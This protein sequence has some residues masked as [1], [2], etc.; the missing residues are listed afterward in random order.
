MSRSAANS[1]RKAWVEMQQLTTVSSTHPVN[2]CHAPGRKHD[3]LA[4]P[5]PSLA[6]TRQ[7]A[8]STWPDDGDLDEVMGVRGD[9]GAQHVDPAEHRPS[10]EQRVLMQSLRH[11]V[12][13]RVLAGIG[14]ASGR[15]HRAVWIH[16]E[17]SIPGR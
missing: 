15:D 12:I 13:V 14:L 4:V 2:A 1:A 8:T 9:V 7:V 16:G 3:H 6:P 10:V 5:Q 17:H 11:V